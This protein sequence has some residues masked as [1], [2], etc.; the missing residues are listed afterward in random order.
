MSMINQIEIVT[1]Q[2]NE[3][4]EQARN[5]PCR[6]KS[7]GTRLAH[8]FVLSVILCACFHASLYVYHNKLPKWPEVLGH[9]LAI[10]YVYIRAQHSAL[11]LRLGSNCETLH[12]DWSR[13]AVRD[14][15]ISML[16]ITYRT[17]QENPVNLQLLFTGCQF[18][19]SS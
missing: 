18:H 13:S 17:Q 15:R 5:S 19:A 1:R 9:W 4:L 12:V 11:I 8:W 2:Q 16:N 14:G 6:Q 7:L 10:A 3:E